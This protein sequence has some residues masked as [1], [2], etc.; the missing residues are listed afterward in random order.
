MEQTTANHRL[1]MNLAELHNGQF[2]TATEIDQL[3]NTLQQRTDLK[4]VRISIIDYFSLINVP[5]LLFA[6]LLLLFAEWFLRKFWG[7]Y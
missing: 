5:L 7:S 1:L 3:T 2:F 4:P 6:L